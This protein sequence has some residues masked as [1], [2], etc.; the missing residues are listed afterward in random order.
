MEMIRGDRRQD[1]RYDVQLK[2][3]YKVLN[4]G[5]VLDEGSGTTVNMSRTGIQFECGRILGE[6][7]DI[8]LAIEWPILLRGSEPLELHAMGR[9][10]R[11]DDRSAA[12]H[13]TW[14][15]FVRVRE[16]GGPERCA[17]NQVAMVM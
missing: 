12:M 8:E 16:V 3:R 11:A 1:R 4:D 13:I 5:R 6:G 17:E 14:H 10:M 9:V 7:M 2:L 15:E